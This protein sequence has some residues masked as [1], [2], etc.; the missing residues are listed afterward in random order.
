[1]PAT[2]I[3]EPARSALLRRPLKPSVTRDADVPGLCLI[4][5]GR[6]SFWALVYQVRGVNPSTGKRWGGGTRYELGD[7]Q[8]MTVAEARGAALAAKSL[9]RQGRSPHNEAMALRASVEAS[10]S[11][12]PTTVSDA[13]DAYAKALAIRTTPSSASRAQSVYYARKASALMNADALPIAAIGVNTVRLLVETAPGADA[14]RKHIFGGLNRFLTWSRKQG[15]IETN[16]CDFLDRS[17]RPKTGKAREHVPSIATLRAIWRAVEQEPARDLV[18][19][20]LLVPLR[21]KEAAGLRW[22]EVD[23]DHGRIRIGADRMKNRESHELPLSPTAR[24]ILD[25]RRAVTAG[26]LVFPTNAGAAYMNWGRM[27]ERI[28]KTIGEEK[29]GRSERFTP[30]DL[31]RSF[32]SNLAENFDIDALDQVLAH[33]RAG[34]AAIY[35]RSKR[36]PERVRALDAWAA[37][38]T[39]PGAD[40]NVVP[41]HVARKVI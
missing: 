23:L 33:K 20:M 39:G 25:A 17:D 14:Q 21:R 29:N 32:V 15:L 10:R 24:A 6:R 12:L 1:M 28:R 18:R 26:E 30:H 13:L 3:N 35:Q 22:S 19:F 4:V 5:T 41:I 9:V 7:A 31:R 11:I 34:V 38:I 37:L 40:D 2:R 16:P 36:W 27:V 8:L